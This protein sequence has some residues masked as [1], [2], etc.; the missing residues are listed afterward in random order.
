MK[1]LGANGDVTAKSVKTIYPCFDLLSKPAYL[2][3]YYNIPIKE[4]EQEKFN[5][6]NES[7]LI[8]DGDD[9]SYK[10][11]ILQDESR[12]LLGKRQRE[13]TDRGMFI[14]RKKARYDKNGV[15][16][17]TQTD[18]S[19]QQSAFLF[20]DI[21]D[22]QLSYL[23]MDKRVMLIRKKEAEKK[24]R[25]FVP[26]MDNPD[27]DIDE[28]AEREF[29]SRFYT[30][31]ER[32]YTE[33]EILRKQKFIEKNNFPFIFDKTI[34]P[35]EKHNEVGIKEIYEEP[36]E[37]KE[38]EEVPL[39]PFESIKKDD[40]ELVSEEENEIDDLFGGNDDDDEEAEVSQLHKFQNTPVA[41]DEEFDDEQVS[42]DV[43]DL[44]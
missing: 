13:E 40:D 10:L 37:H 12:S 32:E 5:D 27:D 22:N 21:G 19:I 17:S 36:P 14:K 31:A 23:P 44:F 41:N 34:V 15:F 35:Q 30:L 25:M 33:K 7:I 1:K 43:D 2:C 9:N 26:G 20:Y 42:E 16:R 18:E 6:N 28:Q 39:P 11:Y 38:E 24:R 4:S 29:Q 3:Q 8:K